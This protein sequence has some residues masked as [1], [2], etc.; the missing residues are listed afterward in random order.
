MNKEKVSNIAHSK[1]C[2]TF[3][4]H[5]R[6][7]APYD[8]YDR[9]SFE[10]I[11]RLASGE[12]DPTIDKD[13]VNEVVLSLKRLNSLKDLEVIYHASSQR[14]QDTAFCLKQFL[15]TRNGRQIK[16][17]RLDELAEIKFNLKQLV[18]LK[19]Y[20]K[21]QMRVVRSALFRA[22]V[23]GGSV[24]ELK[25]CYRR[26]KRLEQII[27]QNGNEK[28]LCITH[29][30]FMRLL[31]LYFLLGVKQPDEVS[32]EQLSNAIN[33]S[34]GKGFSISYEGERNRSSELVK[35]RQ[36]IFNVVR[37]L[38]YFVGGPREDTSCVTKHGLLVSLLKR[39]GIKS[40]FCRGE[41]DWSLVGIPSTILRLAPVSYQP[42]H[43]FLKVLIPETKQHV[44]VDA[45]WDKQLSYHFLINSWNGIN[46]I[47]IAVQ[48]RNVRLIRL[49]SGKFAKE[50]DVTKHEVSN[51][52]KPFI[53]ALNKYF[54]ECREDYLC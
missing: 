43:T 12:L 52:Y 2:V 19:Q 31:Q 29:G 1:K 28:V 33:F 27:L 24:E 26:I 18:S 4:R 41:F 15:E 6:L 54:Q 34:Y 22:L 14:A 30:F 21:G 9:L 11:H 23:Q 5:G 35:Q 10:Q 8:N 40:R 42:K 38:P 49:E 20:Q 48:C 13:R 3:L 50:I 37:D 47:K 46:N 44:V 7:V 45:T 25:E 53:M 39:I 51:E 36:D 32:Q 17:V 16:I